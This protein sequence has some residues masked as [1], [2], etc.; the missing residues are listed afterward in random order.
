MQRLRGRAAGQ[1]SAQRSDTF[2]GAV[3]ID[4]IVNDPDSEVILAVVAFQ[5]GARTHWH[6]HSRGQIL[7]IA[8]G[9]GLVGGRGG[10]VHEMLPG[11]FVH[12]AP[13]EEH[14][15][16]AGPDTYV[17]HEATTL[18][19]TEWL[20]E[21]DQAEYEAAAVRVSGSEGSSE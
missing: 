15:H 14:W 20:G 9:R 11:D 18:G 8:A 5:P 6:A 17:A 4:P 21:V 16:G 3:L 13:D 1:P 10:E 19:A 7:H 2:T 12:I